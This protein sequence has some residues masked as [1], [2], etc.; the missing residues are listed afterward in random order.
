MYFFIF[1]LI[2]ALLIWGGR[3]LYKIKVVIPYKN[4]VIK[5]GLQEYN[6]SIYYEYEPKQSRFDSINSLYCL[7]PSANRYIETDLII[8]ENITSYDLEAYHMVH[9]GKSSHKVVDFKGRMYDVF[10]EKN[11]KCNFILKEEILDRSPSGYT[12][13]NLELISFNKKFN[14][15]VSEQEEAFHLFTSVVIKKLMELEEKC[16]GKLFL[17]YIDSHII[18]GVNDEIDWFEGL[19]T[20]AEVKEQYLEQRARI[21]AFVE[22]FRNK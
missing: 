22:L 8:D 17:A 9:T 3:Y 7:V 14:L 13:L 1:F 15:Y 19:S 12:L 5:K 21:L 16:G 2:I 18:Y 10:Q 20:S 4:K 6:K 11:V